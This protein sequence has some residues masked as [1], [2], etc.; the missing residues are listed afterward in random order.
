MYTYSLHDEDFF[1]VYDI[2]YWVIN[3]AEYLFHY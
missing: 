2:K 1:H 3:V